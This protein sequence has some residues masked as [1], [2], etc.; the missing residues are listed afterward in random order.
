MLKRT[1]GLV[2]VLSTLAA[3]MWGYCPGVRTIM[4]QAWNDQTGWTEEARAADPVGFVTYA[5]AKMK[6]DLALMEKT[7]RELA[8]EVGSLGRRTRE[9]AALAAQA[10]TLAEEFRA[11]YQAAKENDSFP[12]EIRGEAYTEAQVRSQVSL[13]LSRKIHGK[14]GEGC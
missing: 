7:R 13:L 6:E 8:A 14:C 12:I 11:E 1:S 4:S 5:E 10:G 2:I 9:Q 3:A